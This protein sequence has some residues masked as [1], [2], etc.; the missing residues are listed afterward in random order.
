M[1]RCAGVD[2]VCVQPAPSIASIH[3]PAG[4]AEAGVSCPAL[5]RRC[6]TE[7]AAFLASPI[8]IGGVVENRPARSV[9]GAQYARR[10][11]CKALVGAAPTSSAIGR[12]RAGCKRPSRACS[13]ESWR[14]VA[15]GQP[16]YGFNEYC[17]GFC[18]C[19]RQLPHPPHQ[20]IG[21]Q[22]LQDWAPAAL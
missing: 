11:P 20:L 10:G 8:D 2:H 4:A 5:P 16:H 7:I 17:S 13:A 18:S 9:D 22:G 3:S 19:L 14:A 15:A 12:A 6:T 21:S 1:R